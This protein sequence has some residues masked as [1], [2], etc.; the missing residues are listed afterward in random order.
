MFLTVFQTKRVAPGIETITSL[1]VKFVSIGLVFD[2][3]LS[4]PMICYC[5]PKLLLCKLI[6]MIVTPAI[7]T[8]DSTGAAKLA[9]VRAHNTGEGTQDLVTINLNPSRTFLVRQPQCFRNMGKLQH[10]VSSSRRQTH[11][12]G[13]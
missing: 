5:D 9:S 8:I 1:I 12:L 10:P 4:L 2:L 7:P 3:E 11:P 6:T 13:R